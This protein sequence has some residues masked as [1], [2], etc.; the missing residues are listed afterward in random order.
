M[1]FFFPKLDPDQENNLLESF[2][3]LQAKILTCMS[4]F[5]LHRD[6]YNCGVYLTLLLL[7]DYDARYAKWLQNDIIAT[8]GTQLEI[9]TT[10]LGS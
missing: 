10:I 4:L 6:I 5:F 3:N 7:G 2:T 1:N 9:V 8:D